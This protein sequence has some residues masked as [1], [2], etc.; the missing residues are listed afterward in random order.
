MFPPEPVHSA[1]QHQTQTGTG[2][3]IA[4]SQA[5]TS[6]HELWAPPCRRSAQLCVCKT[7]IHT[8]A[9]VKTQVCLYRHDA[10]TQTHLS[11]LT[12]LWNHLCFSS[13]CC[14]RVEAARWSHHGRMTAPWTQ[15]APSRPEI[16]R[17]V[18]REK[19][20]AS[21]FSESLN[22][23]WDFMNGFAAIG[24]VYQVPLEELG[25]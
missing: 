19:L 18:V 4:A 17:E 13:G 22:A 9:G 14:L 10:C 25:W 15:T 5:H 23:I 3:S 11:T 20:A 21:T 7:H 16:W 1:P 12:C 24:A 8:S 2:R 6:W